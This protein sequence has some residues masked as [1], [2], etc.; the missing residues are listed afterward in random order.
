M[1]SG[2]H[3]EMRSSRG[4][5]V[6]HLEM[7]GSSQDGPPGHLEMGSSR[8]G[9]GS[10]LEMVNHLA[11]YTNL[12]RL[13]PTQSDRECLAAV[14]H[15]FVHQKS[16][17]NRARHRHATTRLRAPSTLA[18]AVSVADGSSVSSVRASTLS[19][20]A[21]DAAGHEDRYCD[22]NTMP[23]RMLLAQISQPLHR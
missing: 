22:A 4:A 16:T 21:S 20:P 19:Q 11:W 15:S 6:T 14:P 7:G 17:R 1:G 8:D 12:L 18:A 5:W 13:R 23:P 2:T 9:P 10:H 3:L